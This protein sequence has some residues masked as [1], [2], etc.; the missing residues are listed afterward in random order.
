M[1]LRPSKQKKKAMQK[2]AAKLMPPPP[3]L[4]RDRG[5]SHLL[6]PTSHRAVHVSR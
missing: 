3:L 6:Q 1:P 5:N 4:V 2:Q